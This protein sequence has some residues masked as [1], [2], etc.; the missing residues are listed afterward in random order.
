[1]AEISHPPMEQLQ[2]LEYCIDSNPPW[3]NKPPLSLSLSLSI[4]QF[5][6]HYWD[7]RHYGLVHTDAGWFNAFLNTVFMSPPTVGLIIAVFMDNTVDVEMSKK[8]RGMPWWVKFRNFRGD[9]RNE[10]FYNLPFNLN[11][12][13]PPT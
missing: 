8:D 9:N 1:M 4:P 6:V 2:D 12:F 13:F 7:A 3:R 5:F 10:E 11:R